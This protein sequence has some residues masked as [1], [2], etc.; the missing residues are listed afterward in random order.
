MSEYKGVCVFAE[1]HGNKLEDIGL[2]L[3]HKGREL[4]DALHEELIAILAG[5]QVEDLAEQLIAYGAD[6]VYV[7]DDPE[8][9]HY[10]SLPYTRVTVE[11]IQKYKPRYVLFGAT[12][13]SNPLASRVAARLQ[14]GLASVC[15]DLRVSDYDWLGKH[16]EKLLMQVRPDFNAFYLSTIITPNHKPEI[17]TVRP[18]VFQPLIP[19]S[20]RKGEI[21]QHPVQLP[22]EDLVLEMKKMVKA[23]RTVDLKSAHIIVSGGRGVGKNP[24]L[25]FRLI[26]ELAETLNGEVGASRGAVMAGYVDGSHQVGQTGVTV[27]PDVYVAV[28]ISGAPQHLVG[29]TGSK[30]IIAINAD[31]T[32]PIFEFSDYGIVGDLFEWVPKL[33]EMITRQETPTVQAKSP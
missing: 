17:A 22:T 3:L 16:Y 11:I 27:R 24:E 6:K 7:A 8:L 1:Q 30:K 10:R 15:T 33:K 20:N 4:A 21:I 31:R 28:G 25:G 19:D 12:T 9:M 29:M 18:G 5:S 26:K 13:T 23:E 2:E 32:A 14:T